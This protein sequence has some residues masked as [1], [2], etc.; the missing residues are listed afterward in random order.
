MKKVIIYSTTYCPYC[1]R[2]KA[3]FEQIGADYEEINLEENP[4]LR[5]EL[6]E[7]YNWHTVPMIVVGDNF[8]GGFDDVAKMHMEGKL[9][10]EIG[11]E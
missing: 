3:L 11:L 4:E 9:K 8:L 6:I 5:D 10:A 7:K 1:K 2:A